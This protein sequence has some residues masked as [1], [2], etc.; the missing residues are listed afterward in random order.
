MPTGQDEQRLTAAVKAAA[1]RLRASGPLPPRSE[2][3]LRFAVRDELAT[4][5]RDVAHEA[6]S[7]SGGWSPLPGRL[8]LHAP[9]GRPLRWAAEVKVWDIGQQ[10]W[11]ALK[12]AAGIAAGDLRIG[13]LIAAA[14]PTAFAADDGRELFAAG[15]HEH[16]VRELIRKNA[17]AWQHDLD[18]GTGRPARMS[19]RFR[20][21]LLFDGWCWFGHRVRL[22][23]IGL[24]G[25]PEELPF[26]AGWPDGLDGPAA[27]KA[28]KAKAAHG[29]G[30]PDALGLA[31][32][33]RW[34]DAWWEDTRRRGVT[35]EQFEALYGLLLTRHW[36]DA[37]IRARIRAPD[38]AA[39]PWW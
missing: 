34:T 39:P 18:G 3:V 27:V 14:C 5:V 21:T 2:D 11:D 10:I 12:L 6:A 15:T 25:D 19:A 28:A 36:T 7:I 37:E 4:E 35:A 31:V 22:A 30:D 17:N 29:R 8:D 38:G 16:A 1:D 9:T 32:P 33:R 26:Q 20:T 13:Y 23:R 24:A